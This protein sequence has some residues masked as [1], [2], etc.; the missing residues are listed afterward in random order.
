MEQSDAPALTTAK[1]A[2]LDKVVDHLVEGGSSDLTLRGIGGAVGTSH[3]MLIYHFGGLVGLLTA[4]VH[5]VEARQRRALSGLAEDPALSLAE[6][7]DRFWR[8]L[9]EPRLRALERLFFELYGRLLHGSDPGA[10]QALVAPWLGEVEDLLVER[11]LP[12]ETARALARLGTAVTR[13]LLLDL[14]ATGDEE[15]ADAAMALYLQYLRSLDRG[16]GR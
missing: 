1:Q 16:G 11:G 10:A 7:A 12:A 15:G 9:R 3:R 6:L 2:L 8:Q 14:L 5:E 13:G 4:V